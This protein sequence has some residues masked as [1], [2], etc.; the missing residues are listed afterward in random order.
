MNDKQTDFAKLVVFSDNSCLLFFNKN[1]KNLTFLVGV[2]S[3]PPTRCSIWAIFDKPIS[4]SG[5]EMSQYSA[6]LF[7]IS[8]IF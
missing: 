1:L 7:L 2:Y 6:S 3:D 4:A 8:F 5:L